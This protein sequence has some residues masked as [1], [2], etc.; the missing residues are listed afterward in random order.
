MKYLLNT[1]AAIMAFGMLTVAIPDIAFAEICRT[2]GF[3]GTH[4]GVAKPNSTNLTQTVIDAVGGTLVICGE[5]VTNTLVEDNQSA[6]EA[7]CVSPSGQQRLQ[8][9]RQLTAAAL[10]CVISGGSADCAGTSLDT[11]FADVNAACGANAANNEDLL[12][13]I[14]VFDAWN[15]DEICHERDLSDSDVFDEVTLLPGAAGSPRE[16]NK[17][18][19]NNVTIF[20]PDP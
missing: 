7:L 3:W 14:D 6:I 11:V 20:S 5:D 10:N 16:C 9:V 17:A 19:R 12:I 2:P 13:W 15:N 18:K 1:L 4:A 8:L